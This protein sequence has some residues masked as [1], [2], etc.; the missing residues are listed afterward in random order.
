[1]V[2]QGRRAGGG[3]EPKACGVERRPGEER[4]GDRSP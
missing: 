1:M 2:I 4:A 3:K